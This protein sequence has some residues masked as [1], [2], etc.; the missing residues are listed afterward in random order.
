VHPDYVD[1]CVTLLSRSR[2]EDSIRKELIRTVRQVTLFPH[3]R[4]LMC[5]FVADVAPCERTISHRDFVD[6]VE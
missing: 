3:F 5:H 6:C 2:D 4:C 1:I